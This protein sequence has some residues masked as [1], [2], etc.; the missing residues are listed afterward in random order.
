[1]STQEMDSY[2]DRPPIKSFQV[3]DRAFFGK[4]HRTVTRESKF[5]YRLQYQIKGLYDVAI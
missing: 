4:C 5:K 3:T 2:E 1:M